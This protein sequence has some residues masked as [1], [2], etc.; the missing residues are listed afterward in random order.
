MVTGVWSSFCAG[1]TLERPGNRPECNSGMAQI[2][3]V[4]QILPQTGI[5][6]GDIGVFQDQPSEF[7]ANS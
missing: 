1:R 7:C 3:S 5:H 2:G 6:P 4:H